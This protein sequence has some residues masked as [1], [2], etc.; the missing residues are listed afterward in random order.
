MANSLTLSLISHDAS[1]KRII[2]MDVPAE[3][4][5]EKRRRKVELITLEKNTSRV[6]SVEL[7]DGI[8]TEREVLRHVFARANKLYAVLFAVVEAGKGVVLPACALERDLTLDVTARTANGLKV[9]ASL[10][11]NLQKAR[12]EF[13]VYVARHKVP[14]EL[15]IELR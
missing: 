8:C 10:F 3:A 13:E 6:V 1:A 4:N 7:T 12:S 5:R 15:M 2:S 11:A 14:P 9:S